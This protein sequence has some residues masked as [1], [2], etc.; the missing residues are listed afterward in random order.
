M[1]LRLYFDVRFL[2]AEEEHK[3]AD[4][5]GHYVHAYPLDI[6]YRFARTV[7]LPSHPVR[8]MVHHLNFDPICAISHEEGDTRYY[9]KESGYTLENRRDVPYF[10]VSNDDYLSRYCHEALPFS[11]HDREWEKTV[12]E[13][14]A[15]LARVFDM[16]G[17]QLIKGK[18]V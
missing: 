2:R 13:K 11:E 14:I 6:C 4:T 1:K 10:V 18:L 5:Q 16:N 3:K 7:S 15:K 8:G 12:R 9:V 17:W